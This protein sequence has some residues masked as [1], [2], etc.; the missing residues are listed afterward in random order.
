MG[1]TAAP[2]TGVRPRPANRTHAPEF[3]AIVASDYLATG[4]RRSACGPRGTA[5]HDALFDRLQLE[6]AYHPAE[7]ALDVSLTL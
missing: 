3:A 2:A 5:R 7:S 4:R 6:V 1:T